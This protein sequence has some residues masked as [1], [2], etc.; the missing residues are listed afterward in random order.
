M[1]GINT[2]KEILL[3]S[4]DEQPITRIDFT[5]TGNTVYGAEVTETAWFCDTLNFYVT[6][7]FKAYDG[8]VCQMTQWVA[9]GQVL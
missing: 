5:T 4:T 3:P 9:L 6:Y 2:I 7:P 1:L 8:S